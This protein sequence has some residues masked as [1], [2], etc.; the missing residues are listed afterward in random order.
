MKPAKTIKTVT[1]KKK[2][3]KRKPAVKRNN[4]ISKLTQLKTRIDESFHGHLLDVD[5]TEQIDDKHWVENLMTD[6]RAQG[7]NKLCREDML[8]CNGIWRK[9]A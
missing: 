7:W 8:K 5:G 6:V 2:P 1:A 3:A 4:I 9:Y